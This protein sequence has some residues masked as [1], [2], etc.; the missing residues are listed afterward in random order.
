[1]PL[2]HELGIP[3]SPSPRSGPPAAERRTHVGP[4]IL[5]DPVFAFFGQLH[6][7]AALALGR[8]LTGTEITGTWLATRDG[9]WCD[10]RAGRDRDGTHVVTEGGHQQLWRQIERAYQT[11]N[12]LDRPGWD[13]FGLTVT[14]DAQWVWLDDPDGPHRWPLPIDPR[15]CR[16]PDE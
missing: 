11:W 4:D 15:S 8:S 10:I 2:R 9:T 13:R 7:P 16:Q 3:A 14:L 5:D 12:D 6:L 1:M